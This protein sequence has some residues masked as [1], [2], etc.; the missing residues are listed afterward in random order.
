MTVQRTSS[1]DCWDYTGEC[2]QKFHRKTLDATISRLI[3]WVLAGCLIGLMCGIGLDGSRNPQTFGTPDSSTPTTTI[4][5]T[6]G[7]VVCAGIWEILVRCNCFSSN[8]A[9]RP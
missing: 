8:N 9:E 5:G 3:F 6:V 1:K 7:G 4:S 2:I